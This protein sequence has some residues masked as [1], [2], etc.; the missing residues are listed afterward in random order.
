MIEAG[1]TIHNPITGSTVQLLEGDAETGGCGWLLEVRTPA[2]AGPDIP[3][4]WHRTWTE[5]F[6]IL[7]GEAIYSLDGVERTGSSGHSFVVRPGHHHSHP[8]NAGTEE[9][10]Y[11]QRDLFE[12]PDPTAVREVLGVFATVADLARESRV[13]NQGRVRNPLHQLA[14]LRVLVRHGGYDAAIPSGLQNLLASTL[15][16]LATALGYQAIAPPYR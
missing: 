3:A 8:W 11:R 10:L 7:S 4:H 15:G 1:F 9:L 16:P 5:T 6:E 13:T 14:M 12:P 2:L